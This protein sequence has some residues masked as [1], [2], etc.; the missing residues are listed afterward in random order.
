MQLICPCIFA[1]LYLAI[2]AT[3]PLRSSR[4]SIR[5]LSH[6]RFVISSRR[7]N[8]LSSC[9]SW[10]CW[11]IAGLKSPAGAVSA[12]LKCEISNATYRLKRLLSMCPIVHECICCCYWVLMSFDGTS[13]LL[14]VRTIDLNW[15]AMLCQLYPVPLSLQDLPAVTYQSDRM[16]TYTR[17][18]V[19]QSL[20][21]A[22][23]LVFVG[24]E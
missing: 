17:G 23:T 9:I 14:A 4:G 16:T 10:Y 5:I 18:S 22:A 2:Y 12:G 21:L 6:H 1:C 15:E 7:S 20:P 13:H 3:P 8:R 11:K 24:P 19:G